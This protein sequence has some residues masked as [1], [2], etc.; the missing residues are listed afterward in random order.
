MSVS[1]LVAELEARSVASPVISF[2]HSHLRNVQVDGQSFGDHSLHTWG[3]LGPVLG[4]FVRLLWHINRLPIAVALS[5][6]AAWLVGWSEWEQAGVWGYLA[7]LLALGVWVCIHTHD[8]L[9]LRLRTVR[10]GLF[11]DRV[12]SPRNQRLVAGCPLLE[13]PFRGTPWLFSGDWSTLFAFSFFKPALVKHM[14]YQRF[15]LAAEDGERIALDVAVPRESERGAEG[16]GEGEGEGGKWRWNG[17]CAFVLHGLN[18]AADAEYVVDAVNK[19][20]ARGYLC[21]VLIARGLGDTPIHGKTLFNGARLFD[22]QTALTVLRGAL[23]G[24]AAAAHTPAGKILGVGFS[25]GAIKL[26][27]LAVTPREGQP[28]LDGAVSMGGTFDS[29][30]NQHYAHSRTLWQP[31]ITHSLKQ[32]FVVKFGRILEEQCSGLHVQRA[33]E[34]VVDV[35]DFDTHV[36]TPLFGYGH[37]DEYYRDMSGM[38]DGELRGAL[39]FPL[40]CV[41]AIGECAV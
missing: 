21:A 27:K 14:R 18:G 19:L 16:E 23:E 7:L 32:N 41:V 12:S 8:P 38:R 31:F 26:N 15:W 13:E 4:A 25:M 2:D 10:S 17:H 34:G 39:Q 40:L 1:E 22:I 20:S 11:F 3:V 24:A 29:L 28:W 33:L 9:H 36:I 30:A 6:L 37:V 35:I 5:V